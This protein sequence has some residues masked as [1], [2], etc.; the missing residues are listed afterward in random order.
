MA[1]DKRYCV[2]RGIFDALFVFVHLKMAR[3]MDKAESNTGYSD[4][5][6]LFLASRDGCGEGWI[7][8]IGAYKG[9]STIALAAGSIA[10]GRGKVLSVDPHEEGTLQDFRN[11]I[12]RSRVE[13]H[14]RA[15]IAT[16]QEARRG[17]DKPVRLLFIDALHDYDSVKQDIE[18]WKGLVIEGGIIA[19]HDYNYP[20]VRRA[21]SELT[22]TGEYILEAETGCSVFVSKAKS[23]NHDL[24]CAIRLFNRMKNFFL[25]RRVS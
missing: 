18:L 23:V 8:E 7:V 25:F 16:S 4:L 11:N 21:V 2:L 1:G 10:R 3:K 19:F 5:Q 17:F 13:S 12:E 22:G 20:S 15:V 6:A 9:R 24:F 14:V